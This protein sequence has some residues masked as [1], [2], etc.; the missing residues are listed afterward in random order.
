MRDEAAIGPTAAFKNGPFCTNANA[1]H[2]VLRDRPTTSRIKPIQLRNLE[3]F[4]ASRRTMEPNAANEEGRLMSLSAD[5]HH[6]VAARAAL[7]LM[8]TSFVGLRSGKERVGDETYTL[9]VWR[10]NISLCAFSHHGD[11]ETRTSFRNAIKLLA[12]GNL[13]ISGSADVLFQA[14]EVIEATPHENL[15]L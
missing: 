11:T 13:D 6:K 4:T 1:T 5:F 15:R 9:R 2:H 12:R 7:S 14:K 8:P 10:C 3:L